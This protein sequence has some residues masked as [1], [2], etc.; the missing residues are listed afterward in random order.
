[1]AL[2]SNND[3][4]NFTISYYRARKHCISAIFMQRLLRMC[5]HCFPVYHNIPSIPTFYFGMLFSLTI[6]KS[7]LK[8]SSITN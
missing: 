5:K 6:D 7:K 4:S 2:D 3:K 1:M 8:N